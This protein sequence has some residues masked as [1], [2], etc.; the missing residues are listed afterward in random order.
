MTGMSHRQEH[1]NDFSLGCL[2][3][4]K[5]KKKK[6]PF[7]AVVLQS[8]AKQKAS[9]QL[10]VR[11]DRTPWNLSLI[12][13]TANYIV[14]STATKMHWL[15]WTQAGKITLFDCSVQAGEAKDASMGWEYFV[16]ALPYDWEQLWH[17]AGL[18][19]QVGNM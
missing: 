8:T 10:P 2:E 18:E 15:L 5:K 12:T 16:I 19:E 13:T 9:R 14:L 6:H 17:G 4:A 1:I 11:F 7:V 3:E